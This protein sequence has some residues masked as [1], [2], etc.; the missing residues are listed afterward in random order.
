MNAEIRGSKISV[1]KIYKLF[2]IKNKI[3]YL[4]L[5][6]TEYRLTF[7]HDIRDKGSRNILSTKPYPILIVPMRV[8]YL[9]SYFKDQCQHQTK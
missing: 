2:M 6:S 1:E 7:L 4:K 8:P 5:K 3:L 9:P